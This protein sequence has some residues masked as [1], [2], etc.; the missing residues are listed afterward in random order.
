MNI[1]QRIK[2]GSEITKEID[3][4]GVEGGTVLLKVLTDNDN[5]QAGLAADKIFSGSKIGVENMR[6]YDA[7]VETQ[8]LYR[9]V[10]D[11]ETKRGITNNISDFRSLLTTDIKDALATELDLLHEECSP[12]PVTMPEEE[13]DILL[14]DLKKKPVKERLELIGN[15]SSF[16]TVKRLL[17]CLVSQL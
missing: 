10:K 12:N 2:A 7:E 4:P 1:L 5:L 11:P 15:V 8:M 9:S 16:H 3:W 14:K 17:K 6:N 13:F